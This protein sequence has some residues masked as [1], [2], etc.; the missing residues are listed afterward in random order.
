MQK[1]YQDA[2]VKFQQ[3]LCVETRKVLEETKAALE[4]FYDKK[5][6]G[7]IVRPRARWHEREKKQ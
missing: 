4:K 6:E 3:I 7:I 5:T 1:E 2:Q